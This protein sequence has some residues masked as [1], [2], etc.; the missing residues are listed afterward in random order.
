[1]AQATKDSKYNVQY[2]EDII[3]IETTFEN[4]ID[5]SQVPVIPVNNVEVMFSSL[6]AKTPKYGHSITFLVTPEFVSMD[7]KLCEHFQKAIKASDASCRFLKS[8]I[9]T[10][11]GQKEILDGT[12]PQKYEGYGVLQINMT[13]STIFDADSE[14]NKSIQK[15]EDAKN[16]NIIT[17]YFRVIDDFTGKGIDPEIFEIKNGQKVTTYTHNGEQKPLYVTKDD[18]VNI[19]LRPYF[20]QNKK[21]KSYS[22]KY[23]L[24]S[25]ERVQTAFDRGLGKKGKGGKKHIE[26]APNVAGLEG[27]GDL[28]NMFGSAKTVT[29]PKKEVKSKA[30]ETVSFPGKEEKVVTVESTTGTVGSAP[31]TS[32]V[33]VQTPAENNAQFDFSQLGKDLANFNL[34]G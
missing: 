23:N 27:L 8:Q 6:S 7:E 32:Q 34:G 1:M 29:Q 19:Q 31:E 24:L 20:R 22:L 3:T 16:G 17:K 13:N 26:A 21:D 11:I 4:S 5:I 25:V 2:E 18:L 12:Y 9:K 33:P 30:V 15:Y 10:I 14:D 28:V